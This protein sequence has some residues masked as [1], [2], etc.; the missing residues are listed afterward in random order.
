MTIEN[1]RAGLM[2]NVDVLE[3]VVVK[4][5]LV[6]VPELSDVLEVMVVD[7]VKVELVV[8]TELSM[9]T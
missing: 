4:V 5:E 1:N 8:D 6:V 9:I 7:G 3:V 2:T